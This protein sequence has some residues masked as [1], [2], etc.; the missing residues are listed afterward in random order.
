M[1]TNLTLSVFRET[2]QELSGKRV[3]GENGRNEGERNGHPCDS[4][5]TAFPV[6]EA[7]LPSCDVRDPFVSVRGL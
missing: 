2:V 6:R 3:T 4:N 1:S 7:A 5:E